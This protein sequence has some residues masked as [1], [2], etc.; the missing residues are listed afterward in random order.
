MRIGVVTFWDTQDNYGQIMQCYALQRYLRNQGHDAFLIR[1]K[2]CD[3]KEDSLFKKIVKLFSPTHVVA[4]IKYLQNK[5]IHSQFNNQHPRRFDDFRKK[6]LSVSEKEY[7]SYAELWNEDWDVDV[8]I[9]GSD[10]VWS[11][12][13][14]RNVYFLNFAPN[15][16]KKISYAASFGCSTLP[17][18]YE[19][20]LSKLLESFHAV[21]VRESGGVKLCQT[22]GNKQDARLVCDPTL[23]LQRS[24]YAHYLLRKPISETAKHIFCY[25]INWETNIPIAQINDY[26]VKTKQEICFFP[27][28]GAEQLVPFLIAKDLTPISWLDS[29]ACSS[30]SITNSF[31]GM[32][33]SILHHKSFVVL[34]L[35]GVASGM[36]D[37]IFTLLKFLGLENRIYSEQTS[38]EDYANQQINWEQV[39]QRIADFRKES[40]DFLDSALE[41]APFAKNESFLQKKTI[42]FQTAGGVNHDF[43]GLDRVTE[44][45]SD[46]FEAKGYKVIY[47]SY[48]HRPGTDNTRQ[49]YLPNETRLHTTENRQAFNQLL[50]THKVDVL[51]NQEANVNIHI[52]LDEDLKHIVQLTVLH[53]NPNYIADSYF[54]YRFSSSSFPALLGK[55]LQVLFKCSLIREYGLKYLRN[56]LKKN[57]LYQMQ[58]CD[59]FVMLSSKFRKEMGEL[60]KDEILPTNLCAINNPST[61]GQGSYNFSK[62]KHLLYVG[63]LELGQKRLDLLLSIWKRLSVKFPDWELFLVGDGPD[64][65]RIETLIQNDCLSHVHV[66]G[67][68]S[69]MQ[70]YKDACIFC[71]T[72]GAAEGWGMVLVEAQSMGC[73]PIAFDSYSALHDIITDGR[74]GYI[75]PECN[76]DEYINKLSVLMTNDDLRVQMATQC[77]DSVSRFNPQTIANEWLSLMN[78]VY[79][80]KI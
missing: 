16:I 21:S 80:R 27:A 79:Q 1:I 9:C 5:K 55:P 2:S 42:C 62:K 78:K 4:Y 63:R 19:C 23:L 40:A 53:F 41:S 71:F 65:K 36:N 50:R 18:D 43:G 39:D 17:M 33:F 12:T 30:L 29:L 66:E 34:P 31:H 48:K 35:T 51:I 61:Y 6:Y 60:M 10:Q 44:I 67:N 32:V 76:M 11:P 57:Y 26:L 15:T 13:Q 49:F 75:I 37:R 72:A 14:P 28:H 7:H 77:V 58:N 3:R 22:V 47:I 45:L 56:K 25:L 68:R 74:T 69:P 20:E 24:D 46:E 8:L 52:P 70:Y 38:I 64:K 54:H 73:V 59:E